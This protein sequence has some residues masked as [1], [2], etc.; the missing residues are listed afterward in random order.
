MVLPEPPLLAGAVSGRSGV[1]RLLP[2]VDKVAPDQLHFAGA[3]VSIPEIG[4]GAQLE[5]TAERA[6]EVLPHDQRHRCRCLPQ[7]WG[8]VPG[9]IG[10]RSSVGV[11]AGTATEQKEG[12]Y[13]SCGGDQDGE[14][15]PEGAPPSRPPSVSSTPLR[16]PYGT[17][18]P[19]GHPL[20]FIG[21]DNAPVTRTANRFSS[22]AYVENRY[23]DSNPA[24]I[25]P[26]RSGAIIVDGER[27]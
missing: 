9:R 21:Y 10:R 4:D 5:A 23:R 3:N 15:G 19:P 22:V 8:S 2:I 25:S 6:L 1:L 16:L 11:V 26:C 7:G 24:Y 12:C 13:D 20:G 14:I 18:R 17:T 27:L